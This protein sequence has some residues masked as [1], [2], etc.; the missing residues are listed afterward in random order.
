MGTILR[1]LR[2]QKKISQA[3]MA[4]LLGVTQNFLSQI[5]ND[6]KIMSHTTLERVAN[7]LGISKE[8]L[9]IASCDIPP[10]LSENKKKHLEKMKASML[11]YILEK[12]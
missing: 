9:I 12:S 10:E 4:E 7:I 3:N 5:E 11:S 6:K 8:L 2:T 1:L